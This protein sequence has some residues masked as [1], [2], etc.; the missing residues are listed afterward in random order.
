MERLRLHRK[1]WLAW[2][3]WVAVQIQMPVTLALGIRVELAR[4]MV[5]IYIG[6]LTVAIGRHPCL[7]D[8]RVRRADS[9]RGFTFSDQEIL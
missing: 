8:E 4:P 9:C 2:N 1:V 5:D 3:S 6:P 7:T